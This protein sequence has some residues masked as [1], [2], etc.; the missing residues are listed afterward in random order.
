VTAGPPVALALDPPPPRARPAATNG[1]DVGGRRLLRAAAL[2]LRDA[3]GNAAAAAG[4]RVRVGLRW[5]GGAE[6]EAP[7]VL[8]VLSRAVRPAHSD[9]TYDVTVGEFVPTA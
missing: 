9:A 3:F 1:A 2:Q 6:G 5:P 8:L 4:V 7:W